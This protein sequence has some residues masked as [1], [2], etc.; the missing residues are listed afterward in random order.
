M[1]LESK[2]ID[3]NVYYLLFLGLIVRKQKNNPPLLEFESL[4]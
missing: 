3:E 4:K 1:N 2:I